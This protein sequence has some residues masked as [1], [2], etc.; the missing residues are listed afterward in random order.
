M[1]DQAMMK[2]NASNQIATNENPNFILFLKF[3]SVFD[4]PLGLVDR[5]GT[6]DF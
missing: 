3:C 5:P 6:L 4:R 2:M 1:R